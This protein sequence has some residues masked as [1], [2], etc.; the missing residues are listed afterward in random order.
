M[1]GVGDTTRAVFDHAEATGATPLAAA[2]EIRARRSRRRRG[3][4]I[5]K[6]PPSGRGPQSARTI[7]GILQIE[8]SAA[9]PRVNDRFHA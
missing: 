9:R 6:R 8:D 4:G 7:R 5:E 1:R 3:L 2:M